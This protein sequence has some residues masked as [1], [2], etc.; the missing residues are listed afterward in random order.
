[1]YKP[2]NRSSEE[3]IKD[4]REFLNYKNRISQEMMEKGSYGPDILLL[5]YSVPDTIDLLRSESETFQV[6]CDMNPSLL[7]MFQKYFLQ[8]KE[9][10][11]KSLILPDRSSLKTLIDKAGQ[12]SR[13]I[14]PKSN[15]SF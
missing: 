1:M 3:I 7:D 8:L 2:I 13:V 11:K 9:K 12:N 14:Y 5:Y 15:I 6:L 4:A 10:Y